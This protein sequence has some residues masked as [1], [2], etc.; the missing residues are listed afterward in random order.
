MRLRRGLVYAAVHLG[1]AVG[2]VYWQEAPFWEYIPAVVA[3]PR[4]VPHEANPTDTED[5]PPQ[6][7]CDAANDSERPMSS[8]EKILAIDNLPVALITGWHL[9]CSIPSRLDRPIQARYGFTQKAERVTGWIISAL[10]LVL[11]FIVG[12]FP[13]IRRRHRRWYTEPGLFMTICTLSSVLLLGIGWSFSLILPHLSAKMAEIVS[14]VPDVVTQVAALPMLFV[15]AGWVWWVGLFFY[16]RWKAMRRRLN[17]R[18]LT[19]E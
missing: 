7:A 5:R 9:P 17:R 11:W 14:D 18:A 15:G 16:T 2:L 19:V 8:Q 12:G 10:A 4:G 13:M 1:V 6:N 3:A